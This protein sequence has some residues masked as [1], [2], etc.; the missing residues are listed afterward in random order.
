MVE[1][2]SEAERIAALIAPLKR[3]KLMWEGSFT[4]E[5]RKKGADFEEELKTNPEALQRFMGEIDA[6][7]NESDADSDGYLNRDEFKE[8]VSKMN[9]NGV[10]RGL[11]NRDTT[12]EFIDSVFPSFN[13]FE[14]SHDG[15]SKVE[16]MAILNFINQD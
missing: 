6:A 15:V 1:S 2:Q 10:S 11:K 14:M 12:D 7:F 9:A 8:F 5:E 16:I 3:D 13:G 4:A